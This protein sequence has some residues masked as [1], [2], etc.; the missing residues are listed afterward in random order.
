MHVSPNLTLLSFSTALATVLGV[1]A[2]YAVP[3]PFGP[4]TASLGSLDVPTVTGAT[5][6]LNGGLAALAAGTGSLAGTPFPG[7]GSGTLNYAQSVGTTVTAGNSLIGLFSFN[8]N[9]G[10][11]YV[12]DLASVETT[13]YVNNPGVQTTIGLYLLGSMYDVN[14]GLTGTATSLSMTFNST[15]ASAFSESGSL[16]N[17]PTTPVIVDTPEPVSLA[18]LG[19]GFFGLGAVRRRK[20]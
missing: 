6:T 9:L 15:G 18:V 8:D 14:L 20:Q 16:A 13:S 12:F 11:D 19:V 10:G 17:P 5:I 3:Q 1:C 4:A 2:A 7:S